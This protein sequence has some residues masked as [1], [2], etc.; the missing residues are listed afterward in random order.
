MVTGGNVTGIAD[1]LEKDGLLVRS[2]DPE[3]RRQIQIQLTAKG[4]REFARMA[5]V[6][7]QW[8]IDLFSGLSDA[9]RGRLYALLGSL[10][11]SMLEHTG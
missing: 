10:K 2:N 7:E 5:A 11:A 9:E 6:H 3:D 1:Q 8:I 4:K